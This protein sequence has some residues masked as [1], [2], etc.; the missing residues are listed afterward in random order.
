MNQTSS[1]YRAIFFDLDGTLLSM[2]TSTFMR[3]YFAL[4]TRFVAS[5]GLDEQRFTAA[6]FAG[7]EAMSNH[8]GRRSNAAVF[9]D[10]F[11]GQIDESREVWI[12][13]FESFYANEFDTLGK[14][15]VVNPFAVQ[16]IEILQ[17]KGYPLV[18]TT[19]PMF[20]LT[21][22]EKRLGWA[23]INP[24]V[25][26]RITHFEN[27]T[28][29]KPHLGYFLENLQA[30]GL[31]S[32]TVNSGEVLLVGNNTEEDLA[33]LQTNID[34]Y[35]ITDLLLNPNDFDIEQVKHGSFEDFL[36]WVTTLP[37]CENPATDFNT[38]IVG[39]AAH[40]AALDES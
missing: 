38:G 16:A 27:S 9:W 40:F 15:V 14:D 33:C 37:P 25:F 17:K 18:L 7:I 22:V 1:Q 28:S 36:A 24:S 20:P 23:G 34:A 6:L 31:V 39:L 30:S 11:F 13:L 5:H 21:A 29:V 32:A 12:P 19:M 10:T 35:L 26:Q 8:A 4:L 3:S 2:D